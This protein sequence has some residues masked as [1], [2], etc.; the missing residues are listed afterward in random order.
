MISE[1]SSRTGL[2]AELQ[3]T[4]EALDRGL[5]VLSPVGDFL[6]YDIIISNGRKHL[7][8]QVKAANIGRLGK[9]KRYIFSAQR[10]DRSKYTSAQVDVFALYFKDIRQWA[11]VPFKYVSGTSIAF[12]GVDG[13][14]KYT[15]FIN[16]WKIFDS[17]TKARRA[18]K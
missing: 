11:F 8:V 4:A 5:A 9:R 10:A 2:S 12:Y 6:P 14:G 15:K 16:N 7:K 1:K 17:K 18:K 3:L 13:G